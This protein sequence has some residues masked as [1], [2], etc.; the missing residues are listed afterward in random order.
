[1]RCR[2]FWILF[3]VLASL[4]LSITVLSAGSHGTLNSV[5]LAT[6]RPHPLLSYI[7]L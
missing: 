2:D 1:M 4:I 5:T 7:S 6:V 3:S